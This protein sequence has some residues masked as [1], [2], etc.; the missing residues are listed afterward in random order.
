MPLARNHHRCAAVDGKLYLLGGPSVDGGTTDQDQLD[1]Y[2]PDSD[3]WTTLGPVP[4]VRYGASV[5]VHQGRIFHL[6]SLDSQDSQVTVDVYDVAA[7]TWESVADMPR[8]LGSATAV[9]LD[10][11]IYLQGGR[12]WER[13]LVVDDEPAL[14]SQN[15]W[16]L[17]PD[18]YK[19]TETA[20]LVDLRA[21]HAAVSH[22]GSVQ[23]FGGWGE[24]QG[25]DSVAR[26]APG[27]DHW[28]ERAAMPEPRPNACAAAIEDRVYVIGGDWWEGDE[29]HYG[30][31]VLMYEPALDTRECELEAPPEPDRPPALL[32]VEASD[33]THD[34]RVVVE[35]HSGGVGFGYTVWRAEDPAGPF[36][37]QYNDE[38]SA[39]LYE[40]TRVEPGVTYWYRVSYWDE[41]MAAESPL[42]PADSGYAAA[43]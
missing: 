18:S 23:V 1:V 29:L 17:D 6:G 37:E 9:T 15:A 16:A 42:S 14:D 22:G 20:P 34:D 31:D 19:W 24:E 27:E 5:A 8:E 26:W 28:T 11:Q 36:E 2:D 40:D 10:G 33:G 3:S 7:G 43:R 4:D 39:A 30:R 41:G 13:Y 21:G 12:Y 25:L 35:W 32:W 38:G